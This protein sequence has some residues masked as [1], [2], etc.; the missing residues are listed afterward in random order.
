MSALVREIKADLL[1]YGLLAL[2]L[3]ESYT[4]EN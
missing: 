3:E 2:F 4:D 1:G